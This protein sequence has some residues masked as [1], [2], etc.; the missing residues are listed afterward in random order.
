M[1]EYPVI[2]AKEQLQNHPVIHLSRNYLKAA[3]RR[4]C[5]LPCGERRRRMAFPQRVIGRPCRVVARSSSGGFGHRRDRRAAREGSTSGAVENTADVGTAD[6][7]ELP[8]QLSCE[9]KTLV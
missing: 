7:V 6:G 5:M 9:I 3:C 8:T 2:L 1:Y 4:C